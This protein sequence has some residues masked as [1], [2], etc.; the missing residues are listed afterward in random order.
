MEYSE[1]LKMLNQFS[2]LSHIIFQSLH[3]NIRIE[4]VIELYFS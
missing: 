1:F 4:D 2:H 3:T